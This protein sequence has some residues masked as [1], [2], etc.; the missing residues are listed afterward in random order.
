MIKMSNRIP[1]SRLDVSPEFNFFVLLAILRRRFRFVLMITLIGI[2]VAS[3][4]AALVPPKFTA[5]AQIVV[6]PESIR[7]VTT[8]N[9]VAPIVDQVA[10]DTQVTMLGARDLLRTVFDSLKDDD[11]SDANK[12]PTDL[13]TSIREGFADWMSAF[14]RPPS[15]AIKFERFLRGLSIIQ[16]LKSRVIT[17]RYTSKDP[18]QSA[19]VVNRIV[20]EYIQHLKDR[21]SA[22]YSSE[23][24]RLT[25]R[26]AELEKTSRSAREKIRV[27]FDERAASGVASGSSPDTDDDVA[28][29]NLNEE[30]S[31][32][33]NLL[34]RLEQRREEM[35]ELLESVNADASILSLASPPERPSSLN[36]LLFI[37]PAGMLFFAFGTFAAIASEQTDRTIRSEQ[38]VKSVTD[39][40]CIGLVP[41]LP[42]ANSGRDYMYM[43]KNR[44]SPYAEAI[45]GI[46]A[47][48]Q[49]PVTQK[50]KSK[51][52]ILVTSSIPG[53][54]KTSLAVSL[55]VYA[56]QIGKS[57]LL[58]DFNFANPS[59]LQELD[60]KAARGAVDLAVD[61]TMSDVPVEKFIESNP[62]LNIDY[63]PT[64]SNSI[65]PIEVLSGNRLNLLIGEL[66][67]RYDFVVID[68]PSVLGNSGT[69]PLS[70]L[71]D[72]ILLLIQWGSTRQDMVRNAAKRLQLARGNALKFEN[73]TSAIISQ[74]PLDQHATYRFGDTA[75]VSAKYKGG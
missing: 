72:H 22:Y 8:T 28:L 14:E 74:V 26:I 9:N 71:A 12:A 73:Y 15:E 30:A 43:E 35:S 67:S 1:T 75:E 3:V 20:N 13:F 10:I 37:L 36:P 69:A 17:I 19:R 25:E 62:K 49:L 56:A 33:N 59:L 31:K 54:G 38:D 34:I 44:F 23:L 32:I 29:Q 46:V 51:Q 2:L 16:E 63:M 21:K 58:V 64:L 52:V 55:G 48:L 7:G 5:K 66:R 47:E 50:D 39:V 24:K 11:A 6:E 61:M 40:G 41:K 27:V 60:V 65:D 42:K 68:G 57:V 18:E 45:R 4:I 70:A 53:E